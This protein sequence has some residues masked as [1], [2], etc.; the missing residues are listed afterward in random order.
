VLTRVVTLIVVPVAV[1][2][3]AAMINKALDL[4]SGPA[5]GSAATPSPNRTATAG[6]PALWASAAADPRASGC[7]ALREPISSP[8][9]QSGLLLGDEA[10]LAQ[11]IQRHHGTRTERL[12]VR[13][14][15]QGGSM[16]ATVDAIQVKRRTAP[17]TAP[18]AGAL[19]CVPAEGGT[20]RIPLTADLDEGAA[21]VRHGTSKKDYFRSRA[22]T[23]KPQ[24][25][26]PVKIAFT[27][28]RFA[29]EFDLILT[30][31][32]AG[33]TGTLRI[34]GPGGGSF[35]VTGYAKHYRQAYVAKNGRYRPAEPGEICGWAKTAKGC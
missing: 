32:A 31:T 12:H 7:T 4:D 24:E 26:V 11:L 28:D 30:Y 20:S 2:V 8:Q 16:P 13:L 34:P 19:L 5:A 18:L 6:A 22:I 35:R 27:A 3:L 23:L 29:H 15:L 21:I 9:E 1:A 14:V 10:E 17:S 33:K 25:Q